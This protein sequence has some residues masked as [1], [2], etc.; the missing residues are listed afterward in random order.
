METLANIICVFV[1]I[2]GII[3]LV[4]ILYNPWYCRV[5][6]RNEWNAWEELL[7]QLHN[8]TLVEYYE[9]QNMYSFTLNNNHI[10][11]ID[12]CK[13]GVVCSNGTVLTWFDTYHN[14]KAVEI[15]KTKIQ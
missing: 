13:V 3:A 10:H 14:K 2:L 1:M 8:A 7:P 5:F 11:F 9:K 6:L 4:I 15:L 12:G